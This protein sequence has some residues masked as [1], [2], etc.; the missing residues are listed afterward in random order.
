[1]R[2][3]VRAV[4]IVVVVAGFILQDTDLKACSS[5]WHMEL[6][7]FVGSWLLKG[8]KLGLRMAGEV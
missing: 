6:C 3:L 5:P 4:F 2:L 7:L 1:M 8:R